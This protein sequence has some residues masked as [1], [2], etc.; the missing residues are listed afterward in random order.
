MSVQ[1]EWA[2]HSGHVFAYRRSCLM[3]KDLLPYLD[4][5][6]LIQRLEM[7]KSSGCNNFNLA[8]NSVSCYECRN[9][10]SVSGMIAFHGCVACMV[11]D[12]LWLNRVC[13]GTLQMHA[14][15]TAATIKWATPTRAIYYVQPSK[16]CMLFKHS[17]FDYLENQWHHFV[18]AS[19]SSSDITQLI[20]SWI[21]ILMV[22]WWISN[23]WLVIIYCK[24]KWVGNFKRCAIGIVQLNCKRCCRE[25]SQNAME[26]ILN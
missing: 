3:Q 16:Y 21:A 10:N 25:A 2:R 7:C 19:S 15:L 23:Y 14:T 18:I 12:E 26:M 20:G 13:E 11:S 8:R 24:A 22:M 4:N 17:T 9:C 1:T 6:D 5:I